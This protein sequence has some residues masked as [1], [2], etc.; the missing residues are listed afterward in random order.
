MINKLYISTVD[1]KW[2]NSNLLLVDSHNLDKI[3]SRDDAVDCHSSVEDLSSENI[4]IACNNATEIILVNVTE[5]TEII[6]NNCFSYGRLFNELVRHKR[7]VKNFF[8]EKDFN[9]L[10]HVRGN[11]DLTLWTVGCSVTEGYGVDHKHRWGTLLSQYL[12]LP[13]VSLSQGGTSIFWAADQILRSDI[14]KGDIVVWGLT[15]VP[16]I[17]ISNNWSFDPTTICEY[18]TIKKENQYWTLDYFESETQVLTSIREILQVINFCQ[19]IG[20]NLYLANILNISWIGVAFNNFENFIDLTHDLEINGNNINFI[21]LGSD[22][23]HPGPKQHQQYAE[24]LYNFI[25]E[26]KH[27]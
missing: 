25:K 24:K 3:I 16:R 8:W 2:N 5:N 7:K 26:N 14:Q 27:G 20:A 13:E 23:K 17:T 9:Y 19:K 4:S 12:N 6:N 15:N 18:S 10:K 11:N 22:N 21:D 1:Y